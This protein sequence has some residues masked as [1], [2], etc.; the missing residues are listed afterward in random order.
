MTFSLGIYTLP[1]TVSGEP[2]APPSTYLALSLSRLTLGG[3]YLVL[4]HA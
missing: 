1:L 2:L 3:R 4:L